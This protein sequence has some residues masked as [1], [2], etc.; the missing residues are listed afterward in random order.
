MALR[1]VFADAVTTILDAF[2]DL[3]PDVAYHQVTLGVYNPTTGEVAKTDTTHNIRGA[4][5]NE[6][7]ET[8]DWSK[9][10]E[11]SLRL[12]I[13]G[14]ELGFKPKELQDYVVFNGITYEI[15]RF[16]TIPGDVAYILYLRA[17]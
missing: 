3:I 4:V 13:A 7:E 2:D 16:D 11:D 8:K 10:N 15:R 17:P 6:K 14:D 12:L 9:P 5:Y 1:D